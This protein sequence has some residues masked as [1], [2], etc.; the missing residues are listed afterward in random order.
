MLIFRFIYM[1]TR[2]NFAKN[3][4]TTQKNK[5]RMGIFA[6]MHELKKII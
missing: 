5:A 2:Q 4:F 6:L 1:M 3:D